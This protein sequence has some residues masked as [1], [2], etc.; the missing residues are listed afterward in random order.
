MIPMCLKLRSQ[1]H[2]FGSTSYNLERWILCRQKMKQVACSQF[3]S[4]HPQQ[5]SLL[6]VNASPTTFC[7]P[8]HHDDLLPTKMTSVTFCCL[9]GDFLASKT[10]KKMA[11]GHASF[12]LLSSKKMPKRHQKVAKLILSSK[13]SATF[14]GRQKVAYAKRTTK[15]HGTC[16]QLT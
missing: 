12:F 6:K 7:P 2:S 13:W 1:L 16:I 15:S 9:F 10:Q 8:F 14:F 3:Q 11:K 5:K 4:F